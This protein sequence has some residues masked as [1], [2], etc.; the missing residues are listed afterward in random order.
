MTLSAK[1]T[2]ALALATI[3]SMQAANAAFLNPQ[4]NVQSDTGALRQYF[5]NEQ[6]HDH[7]QGQNQGHSDQNQNGSD[8]SQQCGNDKGDDG[9]QGKHDPSY[10]GDMP[11]CQKKM[12]RVDCRYH[13]NEDHHS[14]KFCYASAVYTPTQYGYDEVRFGVGCDSQTMYND[15]GRVQVETV[16]ERISPPTA[17]FPAIEL[18]PEGALA[19]TGTY[20]STLDIST[21]R[22]PGTCYVHEVQY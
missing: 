14:P 3:F 17:A 1:L 8:N 21:G 5:F 4:D 12:M 2:S 20:E 15:S 7:G 13:V 19:N 22:L 9:K 18:F 6:G 16:S 11:Q 10:D